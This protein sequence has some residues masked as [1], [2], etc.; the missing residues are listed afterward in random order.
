MSGL[1]LL[2]DWQFQLCRDWDFLETENIKNIETNTSPDWAKGV[3]TKTLARVLLMPAWD[4]KF[5]NQV[6]LFSWDFLKSTSWMHKSV[7]CSF[8]Y[9]TLVSPFCYILCWISDVS[10]SKDRI[11]ILFCQTYSL[12]S[13]T[14]CFMYLT[15]C[16]RFIRSSIC[17]LLKT[18]IKNSSVYR[19]QTMS[20]VYIWSSICIFRDLNNIPD[21]D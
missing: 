17:V 14:L 16:Q 10:D 20:Q 4:Y 15:K 7:W 11:N 19:E 13:Q 6:I 3:E 5:V 18:Y 9:P 12:V 2:W 1:R 8:S 21:S